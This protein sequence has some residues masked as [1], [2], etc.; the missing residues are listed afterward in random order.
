MTTVLGVFG[1]NSWTDSS[2]YYVEFHST[3]CQHGTL[4]NKYSTIEN[5]K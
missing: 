3:K 5:K 4:V 1:P 2:F